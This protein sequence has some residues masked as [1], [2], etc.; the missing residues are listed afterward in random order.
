LGSGGRVCVEL[1]EVI[2]VELA[3]VIV[4]VALLK[5][6]E[7]VPKV[8]FTFF[9]LSFFLAVSAKTRACSRFLDSRGRLSSYTRRFGSS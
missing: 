3:E 8:V 6:I 9:I 2:V 1:L 7:V 4:V 5:I